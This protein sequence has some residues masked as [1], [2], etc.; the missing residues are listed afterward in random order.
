MASFIS[1][2]WIG[3]SSLKLMARWEWQVD[4][5]FPFPIILS[6]LLSVPLLFIAIYQLITP[7]SFLRKNVGV[8]VIFTC[9]CG[10]VFL[11]YAPGCF[12]EDTYYSFHMMKTGWWSG[13]YSPFHLILMTSATQ[14]FPW[15]NIGPGFLLVLCLAIMYTFFVSI[16]K[17]SDAPAF[18]Y[19]LLALSLFLPASLT[20]NLIIVRD[21]FFS[22]LFIIYLLYFYCLVKGIIEKKQKSLLIFSIL[23]SVLFIYRADAA[24]VVP[25]TTIILI[26]IMSKKEHMDK[27][28]IYPVLFIPLVVI[29]SISSLVPKILDDHLYRGNSWDNRARNEYKLTLIENPLGYIFSQPNYTASVREIETIEKVFKVNDLVKK[30]CAQSICVFWSGKWNK[31]ST[32]SERNAAFL[33]A[34]SVFAK[35]PIL[36][37]NSKIATLNLVGAPSEQTV[38][39]REQQIER[40][41]LPLFSDGLPALIGS[42]LV[43]TFKHSELPD[44]VFKGE[45]GYWNVYIYMTM[46]L[47]IILSVRITPAI[48]ITALLLFM[49]TLVV[50][51]TAPANYTLYYLTLFVGLP[52]LLFL[53][54]LELRNNYRRNN[55][56]N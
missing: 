53:W 49:R 18:I 23:Q 17:K 41:F 21:A 2:F 7:A 10:A 54:L 50:V 39:R 22:A 43:R 51:L 19:A 48:S 33:S 5:A 37:L 25:F 34:I 8:F 4:F 42:S 47:I 44:S 16:L 40:G 1:V 56:S 29:F 24:L 38:C 3:V 13:W 26:F 15:D 32:I 30:H 52:L 11:S 28:S 20:L 6:S 36:Y 45:K 14:I 9:I 35:N 12:T 31:E 46:L 27:K 55:I